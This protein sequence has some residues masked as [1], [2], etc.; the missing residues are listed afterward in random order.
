MLLL[1]TLGLGFL[2][3]WGRVDPNHHGMGAFLAGVLAF[4]IHIRSE[5]GLDFLA[6]VL[7]VISLGLGIK[8]S[9]GG[10]APKIHPWPAILAVVSSTSAQIRN[11]LREMI[12]GR[13]LHGNN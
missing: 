1:G 3:S 7:L 2:A 11:L 4:G 12:S 9:G 8:V 6:T 5:S 10:M 13:G